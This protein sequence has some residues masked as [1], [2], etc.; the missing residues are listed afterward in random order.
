MK[1]RLNRAAFFDL[2]NEDL[3]KAIHE[4]QLGVFQMS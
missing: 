3:F 4:K 1:G 2:R